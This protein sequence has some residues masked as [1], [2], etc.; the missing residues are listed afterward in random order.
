MRRLSAATEKALRLIA[1]GYNMS[2]AAIKCGLSYTTVYYA[3]FPERRKQRKK[4]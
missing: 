2:Q 3:R 4:S 1:R